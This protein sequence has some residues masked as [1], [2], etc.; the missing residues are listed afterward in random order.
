MGAWDD[1]TRRQL[2][3]NEVR[4]ARKEELNEVDKH[5]LWI[6]VALKECWDKAGKGPVK[7]RWLDVNN[8]DETTA[9]DWIFSPRLHRLK[10]LSS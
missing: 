9:E 10:P 3:L 7:T 4:K 2:D 8:G 1:Q 5:T 6:K